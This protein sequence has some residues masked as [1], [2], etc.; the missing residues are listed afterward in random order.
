MI[1]DVNEEVFEKSPVESAGEFLLWMH[2]RA[3][4]Y[5]QAIYGRIDGV[6]Y[7]LSPDPES[8]KTAEAQYQESLQR[9]SLL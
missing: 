3:I 2:E 1:Q 9:P 8:L 6:T 5:K 4:A 7:A